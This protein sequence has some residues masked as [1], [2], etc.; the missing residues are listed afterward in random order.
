M[1]KSFY[2]TVMYQ[3]CSSFAAAVTMTIENTILF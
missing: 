3:N 2:Y 1:R